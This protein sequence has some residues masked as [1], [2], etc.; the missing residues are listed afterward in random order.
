MQQVTL[1]ENRGFP[2][3]STQLPPLTPLIFFK[4][5][6]TAICRDYLQKHKQQYLLRSSDHQLATRYKVFLC[7]PKF[8]MEDTR[9]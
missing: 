8:Q 7:S 1:G 6:I 5:S 9:A 2:G 3:K 4:P